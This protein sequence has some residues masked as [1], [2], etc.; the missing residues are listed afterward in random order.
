M[1]QCK[2]VAFFI[3]DLFDPRPRSFVQ[4]FYNFLFV[5]FQNVS[6]LERVV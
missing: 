6:K 3:F 2:F 4:N 1:I 5:N